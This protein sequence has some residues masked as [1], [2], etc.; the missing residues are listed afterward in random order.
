MKLKK[1]ITETFNFLHKAY[2]KD[3]ESMARVFGT[4]DFQQKQWMGKVMKEADL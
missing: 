4:R 3:V 2:V 1:T